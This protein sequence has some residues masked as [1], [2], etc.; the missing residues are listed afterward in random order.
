MT[1]RKPT[2]L[3]KAGRVFSCLKVSYLHMKNHF[4]MQKIKRYVQEK[5]EIS[6]QIRC[7]KCSAVSESIMP[8]TYLEGDIEF[9]F[10]RCPECGE[11]YPVCATDSALRADI[12][13]YTRMRN[14]IRVKPVKESF[15][16]RAEALKQKNLKRS[17]ELM[18]THPLAPFLT[19]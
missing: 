4:I 8:E 7:D 2:L 3:V 9:T 17:Q 15:I 14:L 1:G 12:A 10:F 13:E 5:E 16:R 6:M 19:E 11:V 18:E